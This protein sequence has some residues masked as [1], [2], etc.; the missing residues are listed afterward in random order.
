MKNKVFCNE[1]KHLIA[2]EP[3]FYRDSIDYE[4]GANPLIK[5]DWHSKKRINEIPSK[6]N[7]NNDCRDFEDIDESSEDDDPNG[8]L[9]NI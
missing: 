1:C 9:N 4:C 7:I 2:K 8:L 5:D 6:K 3:I